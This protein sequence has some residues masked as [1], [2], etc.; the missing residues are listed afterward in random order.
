MEEAHIY[1][2]E[3]YM[4]L[5]KELE[6]ASYKAVVM[7]VEAN[8]TT[9][10]L[11]LELLQT[12]QAVTMMALTYMSLEDLVNHTTAFTRSVTLV[13]LLYV[14]NSALAHSVT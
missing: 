1:K 8:M 2:R 3:K 4:N 7:S 13:R 10:V 5:T 12:P 6:N 14:L 11:I 9:I